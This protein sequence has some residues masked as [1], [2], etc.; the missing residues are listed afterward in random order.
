MVTIFYFSNFY[1]YKNKINWN[2][3]GSPIQTIK[4]KMFYPNVRKNQSHILRVG[5]E[6]IDKSKKKLKL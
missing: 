2:E 6:N 1:V 4:D 5:A 3:I